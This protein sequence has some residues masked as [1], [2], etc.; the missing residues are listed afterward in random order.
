MNIFIHISDDGRSAD[1]TAADLVREL[2]RHRRASEA[3][4]VT[5]PPSAFSF[6]DDGANDPKSNARWV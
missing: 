5:L 6:D 3:R 1:F 2:E 4:T